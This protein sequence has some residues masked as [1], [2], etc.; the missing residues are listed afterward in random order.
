M[1]HTF[2]YRYSAI[3]A[4]IL[5][6]VVIALTGPSVLLNAEI[7]FT[8]ADKAENGLT[9]IAGNDTIFFCSTQTALPAKF[10]LL[11]DS[12]KNNTTV[13]FSVSEYNAKAS[14]QDVKRY[15]PGAPDN[16]LLEFERG[17]LYVVHT[18]KDLFFKCGTGL[19]MPG[20]TDAQA[21]TQIPAASCPAVQCAFQTVPQGCKTVMTYQPNGCPGCGQVVCPTETVTTTTTTTTNANTAPSCP[22]LNC[23]TPTPQVGCS[24]VFDT[25]SNGCPKCGSML[26]AKPAAP[27]EQQIAHPSDNM[28]ASNP[29][30]F[31]LES[32]AGQ[33]G[34]G[35]VVMMH[36]S[37]KNNGDQALSD[38][39]FS[40]TMPE[41]YKL[42]VGTVPA[43]CTGNNNALSCSDILL[44]PH[45]TKEFLFPFVATSDA[46]CGF[47]QTRVIGTGKVQDGGALSYIY[48][49]LLGQVQSTVSLPQTYSNFAGWTFQ[50]DTTSTPASSAASSAFSVVTNPQPS[51]ASSSSAL[52][53]ASSSSAA[54][55]ATGMPLSVTLSGPT[56]LQKNTTAT[57]TLVLKN[58]TAS[59]TLSGLSFTFPFPTGVTSNAVSTMSNCVITAASMSCSGLVI[60]PQLSMTLSLPVQT[61]STLPCADIPFRAIANV[62]GLAIQSN[63]ITVKGCTGGTTQQPLTMITSIASTNG[64]LPKNTTPVMLTTVAAFDEPFTDGTLRIDL[65]TGVIPQ[66]VTNS[67]NVGTCTTTATALICT[68]MSRD[69]NKGAGYQ[70]PIYISDGVTCGANTYTATLTYKDQNGIQK[71]LVKNQ[72][73]Q[74]CSAATQPTGPL[75]QFTITTG[76]GVCASADC[77]TINIPVTL[78]NKAPITATNVLIAAT[79]DRS[80]RSGTLNGAACQNVDTPTD[81]MIDCPGGPYLTIPAK[82]STTYILQLTTDAAC[83][84][85]SPRTAVLLQAAPAS[86]YE[87]DYSD[88][89]VYATIPAAC[90][91]GQGSSVSSASPVSSSAASSAYS[92]I[93]DNFPSSASS[94]SSA[95]GT[96]PIA[97]ISIAVTGTLNATAGTSV[98]YTMTLRNTGTAAAAPHVQNEIAQGLIFSPVI[99]DSRCT[100][101]TDFNPPRFSCDLS[102]I[103]PGQMMSVRIGFLLPASMSCP[104]KVTQIMTAFTPADELNFENNVTHISSDISC[105]ASA[106]SVPYM[107]P[108]CGNGKVEAFEICDDGN[109]IETDSCKNNCTINWNPQ[110]CGNGIR[111]GTEACDDGNQ[112]DADACSTKCTLLDYNPPPV[113]IENIT[114]HTERNTWGGGTLYISGEIKGVTNKETQRVILT[115]ADANGANSAA[116]DSGPTFSVN[117]NINYRKTYIPVIQ[118]TERVNIYKTVIIGQK[119][120]DPVKLDPPTPVFPENDRYKM[121]VTNQS[122]SGNFKI[123][124][125][126]KPGSYLTGWKAADLLCNMS[127]WDAGLSP[128][129][130]TIWH[131]TISNPRRLTFPL[132]NMKNELLAQTENDLWSLQRGALGAKITSAL[133]ID[134]YGKAWTGSD[135]TGK[136]ATEN[137]SGWSTSNPPARGSVGTINGFGGEWYQSA[138]QNCSEYA[139][140]YCVNDITQ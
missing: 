133:G 92:V 73:M 6:T 64:Y 19:S 125:P 8:K 43:N 119:T 116:A 129:G 131:S 106:S 37:V 54:S 44:N 60:Q 12:L 97:D 22:Q 14:P 50:C 41:G 57:Y 130:S 110:T 81:R 136:V 75:N 17:K 23:P 113:S 33:I 108:V 29:L 127:A 15:T 30:E 93:T 111:E 56:G 46:A 38:V 42:P 107:T 86:I 67:L 47:Q 90:S 100:L 40:L 99:S 87:E 71:Q 49:N 117:T 4:A 122:V 70:L 2:S 3:T 18:D 27:A 48:K 68:G 137:C 36:F 135:G 140:L 78:H 101:A 132:Y 20:S 88:N 80:W 85:A 82:T 89:S 7:I 102:T 26:C 55:V 65:P 91:Q 66:T 31:T 16:S 52:P 58:T 83:P 69:A 98:I 118:V 11:G 121:F 109:K 61:L 34:N 39:L 123:A 51:S 104:S 115:F 74:L 138:V 96:R 84:I 45:Q 10:P 53:P 1:T 76:A 35:A 32:P 72:G 95:G 112:N 124:D 13:H 139:Y 77:R 5:G 126:A 63:T 105:A 25:D 21:S 24:Y 120:L 128:E 62:S 103:E 79:L 114:V 134:V 59:T 9:A 28:P 94:Q